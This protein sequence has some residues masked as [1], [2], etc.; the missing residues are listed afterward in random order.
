M[1]QGVT[2]HLP[3]SNIM[4][5]ADGHAKILDFGVA[6]AKTH[7]HITSAGLISGKYGYF[8]PEQVRNGSLDRRTDVFA[9]GTVLWE[10]L[11]GERLFC[12]PGVDVAPSFDRLLHAPI[13]APSTL[14]HSLPKGLDEVVLHALERSP[15]RRYASARALALDLEAVLGVASPPAISGYVE[16]LCSERLAA[17]SQALAGSRAEVL[18]PMGQDSSAVTLARHN[19]TSLSSISGE[20]TSMGTVA[21]RPSARNQHL[22]SKG[23]A[24]GAVLAGLLLLLA[25]PAGFSSKPAAP[26]ATASQA[27]P[28]GPSTRLEATVLPQAPD[29]L[30]APEESDLSAA[31]LP[32]E[33]SPART[34]HA[35]RSTVQP[36]HV[37]PSHKR[38]A[39][40][41]AAP[42]TRPHCDP[43]T[44]LDPDGIRVFKEECL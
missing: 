24:L 13:V 41:K 2:W 1:G 18:E 10:M 26:D 4:V 27:P 11:T 43:P 14:N 25:L 8:S 5:S 19:D 37:K 42:G 23:L 38:H 6:K 16:C 39:M 29:A 7:D 20:G 44:Y 33:A 3:S 31:S 28:P 22:L 36:P 30:P 35:P 17:L 9:A 34:T 15:E 21:E 12:D 40:K 32:P